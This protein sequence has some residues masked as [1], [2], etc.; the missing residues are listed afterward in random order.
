MSDY[1]QSLGDTVKQARH[2]L[3]MTQSEV[4]DR[5]DIDVRTILNI[6]NYKGNPKM[7][8]LYPLIR[9]LKLD[10]RDIFYPETGSGS[11][12]IHTLQMMIED[13]SEEEA[14]TLI[15]VIHSLLKA[16]REKDRPAEGSHD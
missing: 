11:I 14:S 2:R 6:E 10:P 12:S 5:A 4:A 8:V 9:T 16:L 1:R 13:C 7:E 3:K 15:P